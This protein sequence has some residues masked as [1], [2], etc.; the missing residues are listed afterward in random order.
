MPTPS[1]TLID[2]ERRFWQAIVDHD[3]DGA[4]EL[5][6]EPAMM[7]STHGAMKFDHDGY[8]KMAEQGS[9]V[10]T[11]FELSEMQ[12]VFPN[13]STA[14]LSYHVKQKVTPRGKDNGAVQEMHDTSTW[15]K[16][17]DD[18]QCVIHTETP[19]VGEHGKH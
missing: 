6:S 16:V 2:L 3:T 19:A 7:V 12:V 15:I 10:L 11:A 5:L 1:K 18:W 4:L 14:V 9:M 8:R 13:D 17:G